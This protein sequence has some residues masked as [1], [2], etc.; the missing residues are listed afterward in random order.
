MKSGDYIEITENISG[1]SK[2]T[3]GIIGIVREINSRTGVVSVEIP[4]LLM[5]MLGFDN[6]NI[7]L[8]HEQVSKIPEPIKYVVSHRGHP[9]MFHHDA[10]KI[11]DICYNCK[12]D[13]KDICLFKFN[14]SFKFDETIKE[15][16]IGGKND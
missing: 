7:I 12:L 9:L 5:N 4:H 8:R 15:E 6:S 3:L 10:S 1:N 14:E 11:C 13:L 16:K 2:S